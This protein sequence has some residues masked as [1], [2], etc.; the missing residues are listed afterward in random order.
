VFLQHFAERLELSDAHQMKQL[1][2]RVTEV[3]AQVVVDRHAPARQFRFE[4]LRHQGAA[5]AAG[6]GRFGRGLQ[7]PDGGASGVNS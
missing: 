4:D 3:L 6:R 7:C 1:L 2:A 5:S